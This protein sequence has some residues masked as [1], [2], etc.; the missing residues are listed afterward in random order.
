MQVIKARLSVFFDDPFWVGLYE[1]QD[2]THYQIVRIL[3]GAEPQDGQLLKLVYHAEKLDWFQTAQESQPVLQ[4][5]LN[6]KRR[7]K[8][9]GQE[10]TQK[11]MGTKAQ[12]AMKRQQEMRKAERQSRQS[13][14][15]KEAQV[16]QYHK[17]K[18]KR[19]EKHKGH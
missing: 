1:L 13:F 9:A 3:F 19:K 17:K 14:E 7:Q 18:L 15:K 10:M 8:V 6:P 12:Q 4:K 5:K 16:I 2:Q 11:V